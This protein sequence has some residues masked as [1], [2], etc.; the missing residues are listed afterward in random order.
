MYS[1][2]DLE[3]QINN[4]KKYSLFDLVYQINQL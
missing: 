1:F 2:K 3:Y 4:L